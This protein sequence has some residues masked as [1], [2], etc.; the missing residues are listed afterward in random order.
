MPYDVNSPPGE[1]REAHFG[2]ER[3]FRD[4]TSIPAG[5]PFASVIEERIRSYDVFLVVIG[6]GWIDARG[7]EGSRGLEQA[8]DLVAAE[9]GAALSRNKLVIPP[10]RSGIPD[11]YPRE[12]PQVFGTLRR[13]R[14]LTA[15]A[16]IHETWR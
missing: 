14:R 5:S 11:H 7:G 13:K 15:C 6:P 2:P 8:D 1:Q 9:I 3:V 12:R 4:M 16:Q 10:R